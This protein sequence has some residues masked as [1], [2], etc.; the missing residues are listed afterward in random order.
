MLDL[1]LVTPPTKTALDVVSVAD[2]VAHLRLSPSLAANATWQKNITDAIEDAFEKL[3]GPNGQLNRI[4]LP[5]TWKRYISSFPPKGFTISMPYP[6]LISIDSIVYTDG[7]G[8]PVTVDQVDYSVNKLYVGEISSTLSWPSMSAG[9]RAV[10]ITFQA[11]YADDKYPKPLKRLIKLLAAHY[12]EN[13]EGTI[14]EP[15]QMAINRKVDY[16]VE[17]LMAVLRVPVSYDDWI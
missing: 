16:G 14:N 12:L 9:N 7:N 3:D 11:G 4:I 1:E 2:M 13:L 5:S 6:P 8:S 15:R 10:T 17:D